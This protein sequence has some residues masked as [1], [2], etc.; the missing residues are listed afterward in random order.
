M[1]HDRVK[2]AIK[3]MENVIAKEQYFNMNTWFKTICQEDHPCETASCFAGHLAMTEEWK[4]A[5]GYIH[6]GVPCILV[7]GEEEDSFEAVAHYL[8]ITPYEAALLTGI[9]VEE[10]FYGLAS[11]ADLNRVK[12]IYVVEKLQYLLKH[13]TFNELMPQRQK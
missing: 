10:W 6:M 1:N 11:C 4:D 5:G 12:A 9:V 13:E 3:M 8:D 7:D 2:L